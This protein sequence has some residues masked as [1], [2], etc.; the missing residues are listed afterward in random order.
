[1]GRLFKWIRSSA[2]RGAARRSATAPRRRLAFERCE[3][4]IALST[5]DGD[6]TDM[7][8]E[9][10]TRDLLIDDGGSISISFEASDTQ[11]FLNWSA[12]KGQFD[13]ILVGSVANFTVRTEPLVS[14]Q[15]GNSQIATQGLLERWD[16]FVSGSVKPISAID[17]LGV[18]DRS[19]DKFDSSSQDD[20]GMTLTGP[21]EAGPSLNSDLSVIPTPMPIPSD[22]PGAGH[23]NEGGQIAL[24]PFVAPTGLTLSDGYGSSSIARAKNQLEELGETPTTRSGDPG[25]MEGLRGRA[26]VYEVAD[27]ST[28]AQPT[29]EQT[30]AGE[31]SAEGD[32][33]QLAS[34]N[35]FAPEEV[36][37]EVRYVAEPLEASTGADDG[38]VESGAE[39]TPRDEVEL[40]DLQTPGEISLNGGE[41]SELS[42]NGSAGERDEAFVKWSAAA[43]LDLSSAKTESPRGDQDRRVL[44]GIGLATVL[45]FVPLR[46]ALRRRS[47]PT[48]QHELP[49]R[50]S[51]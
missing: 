47:E 2:N 38:A 35:T 15:T 40:T 34:L 13:N 3:S 32:A 29:D 49:R 45:S 46:K 1:M 8:V 17:R 41:A 19:F 51:R 16:L 9:Q 27:A 6:L 50:R 48:A 39:V 30:A 23:G 42:L 36:R 4:R 7:P 31:S 14:L 11:G 12:V 43:P 33:I 28:V 20:Y 26:V 25:R 21:E 24:T 44:G 22:E 5:A 10:F 37:H 18:I